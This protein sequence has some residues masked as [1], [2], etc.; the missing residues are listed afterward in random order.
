MSLI[1]SLSPESRVAIVGATGGVGSALLRLLED[2]ERITE[3][4]AF[5][6]NPA[7]PRAGRVSAHA[8]ELTDEATIAAAAEAATADAPL[9]L[10]LVTTGILHLDQRVQPEKS[11]QGL[12]PAAMADVFAVNTIGP[13]IVAKHF[14]P[15]LRRGTKTVFAALSARVGSIADNRLGGWASYRASKSALNMVLRTLAIEH[16]R[17]FPESVVA[18]LHPGTV[19]T[20][21]SRPYTRRVPATQLFSPDTAARHL[22]GVV[23]RLTPDDSGKFFAWDGSVIAY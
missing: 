17:R 12:D 16:A 22:I 6:R 4:I 10:V 11:M 20:R 14:L 8:I 15:R 5:S 23:D 13:S 18:A 9:D 3:I 19:D 7:V 1:P 2:D 21:L